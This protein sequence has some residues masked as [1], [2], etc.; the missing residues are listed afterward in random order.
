MKVEVSR[1][2]GKKYLHKL[3]HDVSTTSGFGFC[4]PVL[5]RE[6]IPQDTVSVRFGE[7]VRLQ[8]MPKPTFG[9]MALK[10]YS[11]FVRTADIYHAFE[12]LMS[13]QAY[14]GAVN[15]YYPSELPHMNIRDLSLI[16]MSM[17]TMTLYGA[18]GYS[19]SGDGGNFTGVS[20]ITSE[21]GIA[22]A[23][24]EFHS[25]L[26]S[27][28]PIAYYFDYNVNVAL[29][30][31]YPGFDWTN[32]SGF[33]YEATNPI[34]I[35]TAD[36]VFSFTTN[37][38]VFIAA[39]RLNNYGRN[40]RKILIGLGYQLN[41]LDESKEVVR[42]FAY[43][44]AWFDYMMPQRDMT[45]KD[46]AAFNV[47]E[48]I[49]QTGYSFGELLDDY[50]SD[51]PNFGASFVRFFLDLCNCFYSINPDYASA[52]ITG[53][54]TDTASFAESSV[55][56]L[57]SS[58]SYTSIQNVSNSIPFFDENSV[59]SINRPGIRILNELT[60]IVNI[61]SA[62]GGDIAE[63]LRSIQNS[64]YVDAVDSIKLGTQSVDCSINPVFSTNQSEDVNL[65]QFAG[66]GIGSTDGMQNKLK[67]TAKS[68]GYL[69]TFIALVPEAKYCQAEDP[70][71]N[72]LKRFDMFHQQ[73]DGTTLMPTRKSSIFCGTD[74]FCI[75]NSGQFNYSGGFGNIPNYTEYKIKHNIL[76]GDMSLASTREM[77]LPF[78]VD[79][80][81]PFR[82]VSVNGNKA[83]IGSGV[84][85]AQL[86]A[87][88]FWRWI[89]RNRWLGNFNRV[90]YN[91]GLTQ[92]DLG[93]DTYNDVLGVD[94]DNFV[95]QMYIDLNVHSYA[96][97]MA[98]SFDTGEFDG[99]T[100]T[101]Q[102]S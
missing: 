70:C 55:N 76:N 28:S 96:K 91:E 24:G 47:M 2:S 16:C 75:Q 101:V 59:D 56:Y 8:P 85:P 65:G 1:V 72:H 21:E 63:Y 83:H 84:R 90:F 31:I 44:K 34:P 35:D 19:A 60:K 68:A 50:V 69:I 62:V 12:S 38:D 82:N 25:W 71:I 61:H 77:Y 13:G 54:S 41:L 15:Q 40:L 92:F 87:G 73:F 32:Y 23:V 53:M 97:P 3:A 27:Y 4:Q 57:G 6:L 79:K 45:W 81:L 95:V 78:T 51:F 80:I 42:L 5:C 86:V 88:T 46:T 52:H 22:T 64:E 30:D 7:I 29:S 26:D 93:S 89:G 102:K 39:I 99:E 66:Q 14:N 100:M 74:A 36:Y 58:G 94:D 33:Q 9:N 43:Y 37:G 49:E 10:T 98:L 48:T 17:S 18:S 20:A 67:F 11:S